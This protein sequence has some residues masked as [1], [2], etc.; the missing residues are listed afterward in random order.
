MMNID[1]IPVEYRPLSPLAYL[2]YG[3]LFNIP[4]IGFV[5]LIIFSLSNININR[6]NFARSYLIIYVIML[7]SGVVFGLF[8]GFA[9]VVNLI[10]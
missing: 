8:G 10:K 9:Y 5:L 3:V 7:I 2:W 4:V 1:K 6:R